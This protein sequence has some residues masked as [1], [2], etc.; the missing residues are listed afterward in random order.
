MNA[1][2]IRSFGI[3]MWTFPEAEDKGVSRKTGVKDERLKLISEGCDPI[4]VSVYSNT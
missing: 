3:R 2:L 1:K 4:R